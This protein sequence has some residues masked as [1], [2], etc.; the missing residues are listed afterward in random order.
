MKILV[1]GGA[2][3][4]G[5]MVSHFLID[6]GYEV[7]IID[8]LSTG[9][10]KLLPENAI[11]YKLD[12]GLG[13]KVTKIIKDIS[14]E[15]IIHLAASVEVEESMV[16][17]LKYYEN[18]ISKSILFL[19]SVIE[20]NIQNLIFS[21][22]AAVYGIPKSQKKIK[23]SFIKN[24]KSP[25]GY[26][27]L[28][29]E[30]IIKNAS[31]KNKL[32]YIILR[33]FNVAGA[34]SKLRTGQVK[35]PATHLIKIACE[36]ATNKRQN[37]SIFGNDYNTSDG[38]CVRDYIH[39]ADLAEIHKLAID[40]LS[41]GGSSKILNCGYGKG[42]SVLQVIEKVKE[43][44]KNKFKV[45]SKPRRDG[46]PDMLVADSDLCKKTLN[47]VPKYNSIDQIIIDSLE[48]EKNQF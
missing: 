16:N 44:S 40:Y 5:S 7:H 18:N 1:T 34:D 43:V 20:A 3:Y 48:W 30:N 37:I 31:K 12:I 8:N 15:V 25:Y 2:G 28:V 26:S 11:F 14:P 4:I 39:I 10:I 6:N 13:D 47:W 45:L 22:T 35:D 23:E 46:D 9:S 32:N 33:Y 29:F 27:K 17:P 21:S 42:L 41:R 24:P 38:T 19:K 36:V